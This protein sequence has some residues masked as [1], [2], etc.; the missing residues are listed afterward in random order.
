MVEVL[1]DKIAPL[2]EQGLSSSVYKFFHGHF[3]LNST[4]CLKAFDPLLNKVTFLQ[5]VAMFQNTICPKPSGVIILEY[6]YP[7][8]E[9][10]NW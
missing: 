7:N 5:R 1:V 9:E 2:L 3:Y 10:I 6:D 4:D 8:T